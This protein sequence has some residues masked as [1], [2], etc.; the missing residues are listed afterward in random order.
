MATPQMGKSAVDAALDAGPVGFHA[1][2]P[3]ASHELVVSAVQKQRL[4][5]GSVATF[6]QATALV[7]PAEW[8]I[9]DLRTLLITASDA[10][11]DTKRLLRSCCVHWVAASLMLCALGGYALD[12]VC[13][14]LAA[15]LMKCALSGC[16]RRVGCCGCVS[17]CACGCC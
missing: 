10:V 6:L 16:P 12:V 1:L 2:A 9:D 4:R 8:H 14:G 3:I 13:F 11:R 15:W 7:P 17:V 5:A